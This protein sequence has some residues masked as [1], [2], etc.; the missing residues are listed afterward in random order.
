MGQARPLRV[1]GKS[2]QIRAIELRLED[3]IN[4]LAFASVRGGVDITELRA[5]LALMKAELEVLRLRPIS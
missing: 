1:N 4:E 5:D 2:A 3:L